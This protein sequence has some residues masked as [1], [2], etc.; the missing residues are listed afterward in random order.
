MVDIHEKLAL[1]TDAEASDVLNRVV[2]GYAEKNSDIPL[3]DPEAVA[4]I[5]A[6][7]S[8]AAE[9]PVAFLED[10]ALANQAAAKRKLLVELARDPDLRK[11]VQGAIDSNR[12]VL[13]DPVTTAL[14]MAGVVLLLQTKVKIKIAKKSGKHEYSVEVSKDPTSKGIIGKIFSLLS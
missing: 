5:V 9:T 2:D 12:R 1:L 10:A 13:L 4:G 11:R 3:R 8:E 6:K 7:I 14:V